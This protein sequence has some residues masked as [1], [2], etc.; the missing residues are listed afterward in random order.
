MPAGSRPPLR[1]EDDIR[2]ALL[3]LERLAPSADAVLRAVRDARRPGSSR[4]R[5]L[6]RL[7]WPRLALALAAV[8]G[9]AA[10]VITL[11]PGS[12]SRDRSRPGPGPLPGALPSASAVARAMLTSFSAADGDV[13]YATQVFTKRG[14]VRDTI[15]DWYWPAQP[16][17]GQPARWREVNRMRTSP[18]GPLSLSEDDGISYRQPPGSPATVSGQLTV[19][20]YPGP[21]QTGCG[22]GNTE[23]P[24]GRWSTHH[25]R[26][27]NPTAPNPISP[28]ALAQGI[29]RGQWRV[30]GRAQLRGQH[31]L[32]LTQTPSGFF[33]PLPVRL[34]VNARTYLPI[35]MLW[36][37]GAAGQNVCE[38]YYL[39]PT[40]AH[41]ALL[42]VPI[43]PGYPR[44]G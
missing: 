21:G 2:A 26:W 6:L 24:T 28:A 3:G 5:S 20:C 13:L 42:Q 8:A 30:T 39:P 27:L 29:A 16:A 38:W 34:W 37:A 41:R 31:A 4:A 9:A 18:T 43:P 40:P 12:A 10:L 35:K 23:T 19:V 14:V 11:L 17:P 25:G 22:F 7:R 32:E 15:Q 44:A 33:Q 1:T 36:G